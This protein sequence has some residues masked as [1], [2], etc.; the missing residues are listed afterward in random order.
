MELNKFEK[1]E[2]LLKLKDE[3]L[4]AKEE[5]INGR[6]SSIEEVKKRLNERREDLVSGSTYN[7]NSH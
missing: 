2:Q 1:R 7:T 4:K 6:Y 5:R 3:L